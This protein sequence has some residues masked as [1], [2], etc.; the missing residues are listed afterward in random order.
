VRRRLRRGEVEEGWN[1][2]GAV[3]VSRGGEELL[4][5]TGNSGSTLGLTFT[6]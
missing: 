6:K 1:R 3:V 4:D 2:E 5:A